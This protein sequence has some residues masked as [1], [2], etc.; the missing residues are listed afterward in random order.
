MPY[1]LIITEKPSAANKIATALADGKPIKENEKG[2][3]YYKITHGKRDIVVACAVGHL[4]GLSEKEKKGW[5]F[6]VFEIEW[7]PSHKMSKNSKFTK[8]Y[9]DA[10]KKLSK[11]ADEFTVATDYDVEGEV[12]GY[13]VVRFICK[14]KDANRMKFSTLTKPDLVEAYNK[15]SKSLDWGQAYAGETRHKLDWIN[16]INYSRALTSS[17]KKAGSFKLMS[18]GR[19]QGPT[20]KIIVDREKEIKAFK[21][22]PFW[23]IELSGEAKKGKI[24]AWHKEDK[25][26]EKEKALKVMEKVKDEKNAKVDDVKKRK[27]KQAAPTPFDLTTLQTEAYRCLRIPPKDTLATAQELYTSG[28]IS[29][30]R[31]SSQQ[32]DPKLG[33]AKILQDLSK[34]ENYTELSKKILSQKTLKPNNGKKTDPAHPAIYPTGI[35]PSLSNDRERKVYDLIV[36]RFLATFAQDATRQTMTVDVKCKEEIFIAKGTTTLEKGW[37]E[38]YTPYVKLEEEELP[39][40][41][42]NDSVSVKKITMHDKE[43]QPPKRYTPASIIKE[44]EKRNLGTKA[45]RS[46]I[47]DTL[48]KRGYVD[49]KSI[50]ATELGIRTLETLEK[51]TPKIVEE[52]LTRH[53]EEEME[54]IREGKAQPDKVLDNAKDAISKIIEDFKKKEADIG[55]EL[56]SANK[57]TR[58]AMSNLGKCPKCG[59]GELHIRRGKFGSFAACNKYPDCKTTFSLPRNGMIKPSGKVCEVCGFPMVQVIKAK[60]RPQDFCLNPRCESKH[61][62]GEAGKEAKEIAQGIVEKECPNCKDGKLVLRGSIYGKFY[63]CSN[64]P[65]CKYTEKLADGPLKEDFTETEKK[66]V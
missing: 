21:P 35:V 53:F 27:F 25:F 23:Q 45:T 8:K 56:L 62:E 28:Y 54:D 31:T 4:Y 29:Y 18:T 2:V 52:E 36:K 34:Q 13:N 16:G 55:K 39:A 33:F 44:L 66:D 24:T 5:T 6:P 57:E 64:F 59:D 41:E 58:D 63:G 32:L 17:I 26:W 42:K 15:K 3:P 49:G 40:V 38:F 1:E 43:T 37:H 22:E 14:K 10:I 11:E 51:Y 60:K 61:V 65:K 20:L 9:L 48:F 50:E 30:P 47:V 46:E 12:I 19:V 7:V